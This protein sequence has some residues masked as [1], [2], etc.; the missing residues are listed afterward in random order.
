MALGGTAPIIIFRFN[1]I[2]DTAIFK[3]VSG[4]PVISDYVA[5]NIGLPIPFYLDEQRT[6]VLVNGEDKSM[7]IQNNTQNKADGKKAEVTQRGIDS[8]ITIN[9]T[10]RKDSF[11]L[12][13]LIAMTDIAFQKT[14]SKEYS[15][16]YLN[17]PVAIFDTLLAGVTLTSN[18]D[19]TKVDL[20]IRL[21]RAQEQ[22][23][24]IETGLPDI[25]KETAS[26]PDLPR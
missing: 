12:A 20:S 23:T 2:A 16:S 1:L 10:A 19:N 11:V 18:P 7:E 21:S 22:T 25:P 8:T 17:G 3:A 5:K 4:I 15:I 24:K 14:V 9:M 6:G 13:A 26:I